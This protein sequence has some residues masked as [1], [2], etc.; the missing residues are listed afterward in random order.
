[1]SLLALDVGGANLKAADGLG[2]ALSEP[3]PLWQ[4][5]T[6]LA[7]AL[8]ALIGRAPPSE[9]L[10]VTM[11]GE[12]ADCFQTKAEGVAHIALAVQQAAGG[13]PVSVYLVDGSL[14]SVDAACRQPL[15]AAASNW[16]A[17]ASFAARY[18]GTGSGLLVDMGSTTTDIIP[19]TNG[20]VV[21]QGQTDPE[22]LASGELVYTGVARSPVCAVVDALPWRGRQVP[23]AQE[24]FATTRDA[25]LLLGDLPEDVVDCQTADG[26]PATRAAARDRLARMICADR[27]T[28]SEEDAVAAAEAVSRGQLSQLGI[29]ARNVLRRLSAPPQT[30][31][32]SGQGEFLI[33]RLCQ[34]LQVP[35][36]IVSFA[37]E[38]GKD[39]SQAAAAHALAVLARERP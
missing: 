7:A 39:V 3:F 21:A 36:T 13:R 20:S 14:V 28:F 34:R 35:A 27:E 1:M 37:D 2:F 25:Y 29:A 10:V 11:T 22:R 19:L 6:E 9:K 33:R 15:L 38:L 12:L 8:A 18:C 17:L 5:P 31:I 23:V 24:L 32:I 26:R 4:R 30:I 16:H